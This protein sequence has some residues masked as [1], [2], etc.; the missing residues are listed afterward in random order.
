MTAVE[1]MTI[2]PVAFHLGPWPVRWYAVIIV[3]GIILGE[4]LFR[5]EGQRQGIDSDAMFDIFF[6][7]VIFGFVGARLYYVL[8]KLDY[9]LAHPAQIIQIWNGGIAIYGG[10]IGGALTVIYLAK[11]KGLNF[12]TLFDFAAPALM[13]SQAIGRWGNFVNQE[14]HGGQVS[15]SFLEGLG[16]PQCIIEQMYINGAYYQPTFLYESMWNLIG[17]ALILSIRHKKR[18]LLKGEVAVFYLI[19]YGIGR[20]F[21][22]GMR[23]DSLYWGS[24]RVSQWLSVVLI[25]LALI[26]LGL[27]RKY[28]PDNY[29]IERQGG[30]L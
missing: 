30:R 27:N 15:R 3:V 28:Q 25:L 1:V 20:F 10:V 14:A 13:L 4:Y 29:Y 17:F 26:Y 7:A 12:I 9:Y 5:R 19:W 6:Y 8:F 11:R 23:T 16:L 22:E 18:F 24:L 2:D 21:I